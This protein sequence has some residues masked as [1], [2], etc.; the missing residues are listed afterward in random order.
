MTIPRWPTTGPGC[1]AIARSADG[2]VAIGHT[3]AVARPRVPPERRPA[4]APAPVVHAGRGAVSNPTGRF[5]A[6]DRRAF[7]DG[8]DRDDDDRPGPATTVTDET[9]ASIIATNDSPDVP[10]DRSINPYRGCEHGC[11]Y[12]FARPTHAYLG[13]SPGLD[14][15]TQLRAKP[16]AAEV[17][18]RELGRASYTCAPVNLGANTDPYQPVERD[19]RITRAVLEVLAACEH[20]VTIITKSALVV[21]DLDLLAPMAARGLAQ[22]TLSVTTLDPE[23][24]AILEPRAARPHRRLAAIERLSAAGVPV[25]IFTSPMIP[26]I[27]D[28]ELEALLAA[29]RAAG[30]VH[31]SYVLLRL[32]HELKQLFDDWLRAHFP[33]RAERVLTLLRGT[34]GGQLYDSDFRQRMRG[35]GP[36]ADLLAQRFAVTCRRLG[37]ATRPPPL[38]TTRFTPPARPGQ[39]RLF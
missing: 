11:V 27:N 9:I 22:V 24:A 18:R 12:C 34:R 6:V 13:L 1:P 37:L 2:A 38:D 33:D 25:G 8:W 5:E 21:R 16:A 26:A 14:F 29:G 28:G 30:A 35:T 17:L 7:D 15:E 19:R 20:P 3:A 23:L 10:F 39:L 32:P 31:A 36:Y 4:D